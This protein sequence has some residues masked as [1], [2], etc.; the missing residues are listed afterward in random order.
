M[1]LTAIG[2]IVTDFLTRVLTA[3]IVYGLLFKFCDQP[4]QQPTEVAP[5]NDTVK[6]EAAVAKPVRPVEVV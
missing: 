3:M 5:A 6:Y 4:P 2:V 1:A